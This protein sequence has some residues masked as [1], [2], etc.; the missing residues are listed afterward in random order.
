MFIYLLALIGPNWTFIVIRMATDRERPGRET[1]QH[2][3]SL[4]LHAAPRHHRSA[5]WTG[6]GGGG[7]GGTKPRVDR[8]AANGLA[9]QSSDRD[10][11]YP[12]SLPFFLSGAQSCANRG[13][14]W[15]FI[16]TPHPSPIPTSNQP[17][18]FCEREVVGTHELWAGLS[19][20]EL[21]V[22]CFR[23]SQQMVL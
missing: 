18:G 21:T 19:R 4:G 23:C 1:T 9:R 17:Y 7:C 22:F 5:P 2:I 10:G 13:W 15:A 8:V 16:P 14:T 12:A 3:V 20:H 6:T 11:L